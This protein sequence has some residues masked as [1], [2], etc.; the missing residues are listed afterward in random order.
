MITNLPESLLKYW[1]PLLGYLSAASIALFLLFYKLGTL[2][3]SFSR[4]ETMALSGAKSAIDIWRSPLNALYEL[5]NWLLIKL[6]QSTPFS[7]RSVSVFFGIICLVLF[8]ILIKTWNTRRIAILGT[9]LFGSSAWFLHIARQATPDILLVLSVLVI[10]AYGSWLRSSTKANLALI[11]GALVF[12]TFAYVPGFLLFAAAGIIWQYKMLKNFIKSTSWLTRASSLLIL[13][14]V[15][16]PLIWS[17]YKQPLVARSL[18]GLPVEGTFSVKNF[19]SNLLR[20]PVYLF[21]KGAVHP[22]SWLANMP[23]I[24]FFSSAM[25]FI[26]AYAYYLRRKLDRTKTLLGLIIVGSVLSSLGGHVNVALLMPVLFILAVAGICLL[27][28][29]WFSVFPRNPLARNI[30]TA[31]ISILILLSALLHIRQYYV[32]WPNAPETKQAFSSQR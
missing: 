28:Q 1:R 8:Y 26:G 19:G 22:S 7:A 20:L 25:A 3:P 12:A 2:V 4:G 5:P 32:A 21:Y 27:L 29:Q 14:I 9:A 10:L 17:I 30:G 18:F 23:M 6:G 15:L 13:L 24:S 31:L 11:T 16:A